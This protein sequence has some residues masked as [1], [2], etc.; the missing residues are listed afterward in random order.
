MVIFVGDKPSSKN[1]NPDVPFVGTPSYVNLMQWVAQLDIH[2]KKFDIINRNDLLQ[3]GKRW[4]KAK[5][6]LLGEE[7]YTEYLKLQNRLNLNGYKLPH[8]SPLNR[9]LNDKKLI[10]KELNQCKQWLES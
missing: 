5:Y 4:P 2:W 9:K 6:I 7:A 3:K 8:P 10:K 1:K